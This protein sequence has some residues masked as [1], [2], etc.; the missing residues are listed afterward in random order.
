M[1]HS[2]IIKSLP[3][4][5]SIL[6]RK[7]GVRVEIG[8]D[9]AYTDGT[10]IHLPGLPVDMDGTNLNLIR[11]Y[12]DHESA[13]IRD[14]DF[15]ALKTA[16][17]TPLEKT[18]WNC[19]EDWRVENRLASVFPGCRENFQWL[20]K[21][22][23]LPRTGD[24]SPVQKSESPAMNILE[25]LLLTVRSWDVPELAEQRDQLQAAVESGFP[26]LTLELEPVLCSIPARCHSTGEAIAIAREITAILQR[27]VSFLQEKAG[28]A[29]DRNGGNTGDSQNTKNSEELGKPEGPGDAGDWAGGKRE[30]IANA[31][32]N[33]NSLLSAGENDLPE[34]F[35]SILQ[36][37][38]SNACDNGRERL[39]VAVVSGKNTCSLVQGE[40]DASRKATTALRT[41]L[42]ALMQ[43]VRSVRNHSGYAGALDS[44]RLHLLATGSARV[45]L[46]RGERLGVNTAAHLLLDCSSS[47]GGGRMSLASQTCFAVASALQGIR[48][49]SLGVTAFPGRPVKDEH[50]PSR[51]N[52]DTVAPILRHGQKIHADFGMAGEGGTPLAPALW[53]VLQQLYFLP[54]PRKIVLLI[55]DGVPDDFA[56]ARTAVKGIRNHGVEVYGIGMMT[57]SVFNLLP[58]TYA[59]KITDINELAPAVFGIL[60]G[61]LIG[62]HQA[63]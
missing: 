29:G 8:G 46:R 6:G 7:Y 27:Y 57:D 48:G 21:H 32:Q 38:V 59:R 23:F 2:D 11:G 3:L 54:E 33:L 47:M 26:G 30:K 20:I 56:A 35:G 55:T 14:T 37:A 22:L 41:R 10:T 28:E 42:Q 39:R 12:T 18:V 51:Q 15:D 43:S 19:L 1:R 24:D 63:S 17:L 31:L 50:S 60:Q 36:N 44:R 52:D 25:W 5:A 4:L 53:W 16:S 40:M 34:D 61:V 62:R 58:E 9:T 45:F 13:H 49:V